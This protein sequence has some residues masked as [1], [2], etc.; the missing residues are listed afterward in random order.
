MSLT[1]DQAKMRRR[2]Q[3][4]REEQLKKWVEG[5]STHNDL[6]LIVEHLDETGSVTDVRVFEGPECCPDFSCC[7]PHMKW[8]QEIRLAFA[9]ASP[10]E[11]EAMLTRGLGLIAQDAYI[12]AERW[13][14]DF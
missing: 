4:A 11:R 12:A 5:E 1:S 2:Y 6:P 8:P 7:H 14:R 3:E 9:A 10:K 13:L